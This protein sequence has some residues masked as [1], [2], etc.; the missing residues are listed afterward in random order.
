MFPSLRKT[1]IT[2]ISALPTVLESIAK[3]FLNGCDC[4]KSRNMNLLENLKIKISGSLTIC[5]VF[6]DLKKVFAKN[7]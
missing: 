1:L 4:Q 5:S 3:K 2:Q 7:P 6:A